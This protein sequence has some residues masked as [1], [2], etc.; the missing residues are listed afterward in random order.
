MESTIESCCL[1]KT[2]ETLL[3]L[4]SYCLRCSSLAGSSTYC[5]YR[6]HR[7]HPRDLVETLQVGSCTTGPHGLGSQ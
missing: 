7:S 6:D 4:A 3:P 5:R 1:E 2:F